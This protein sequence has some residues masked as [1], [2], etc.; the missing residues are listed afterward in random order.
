[1]TR[2]KS[3]DT[4][5]D[6]LE[7]FTKNQPEFVLYHITGL[8][9]RGRRFKIVTAHAMHAQGFNIY[10]GSIWGVLPNGKRRLLCRVYN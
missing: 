5:K 6:G 8:D 3:F 10:N 7:E 4:R 2:T 9:F 1:M